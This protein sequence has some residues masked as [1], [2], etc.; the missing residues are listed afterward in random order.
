MEKNNGNNTPPNGSSAIK[1]EKIEKLYQKCVSLADEA[2]AQGE[3]V[4]AERYYQ[5]ADHY[6]RVMG[7]FTAYTPPGCASTNKLPSVLDK[8]S[9]LKCPYKREAILLQFRI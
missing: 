7:G 1:K 6:F 4:L 8:A 3:R 2:L 5:Q 9:S